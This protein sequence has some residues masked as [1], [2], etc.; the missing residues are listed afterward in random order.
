MKFD[1]HYQ[2]TTID[3]PELVLFIRHLPNLTPNELEY[4]TDINHMPADSEAGH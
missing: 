2:N 4:M 1:A 3:P